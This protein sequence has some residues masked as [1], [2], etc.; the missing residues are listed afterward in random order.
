MAGRAT[1]TPLDVRCP[2]CHA[3][4]GDRCRSVVIGGRPYLRRPHADRVTAARNAEERRAAPRAPGWATD[5]WTCPD[6][7][8]SY[9]PP[10]EWEAPL[11]PLLRSVIQGVHA[12]RH[13]QEQRA[14]GHGGEV[15][16]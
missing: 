4:P 9:W 10:R 5:A 15:P 12:D 6:C 14:A 1:Y 16:E 3:V 11:W 13:R 2:L 8:R 7:S